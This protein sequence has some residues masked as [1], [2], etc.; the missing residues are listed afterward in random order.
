[1]YINVVSQTSVILTVS[2]TTEQI[3]NIAETY[4]ENY[5]SNLKQWREVEK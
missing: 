4:L 5:K 2:L 1:M 3:G